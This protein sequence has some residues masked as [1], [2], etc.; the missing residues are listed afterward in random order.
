MVEGSAASVEKARIPPRV[1]GEWKFDPRAAEYVPNF[2]GG[3]NA[4]V[5][6]RALAVPSTVLKVR[7]GV[8][9]KTN[10]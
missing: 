4:V 7:K 2:F 1:D 9:T 8:S 3:M 10:Q 5:D 6:V